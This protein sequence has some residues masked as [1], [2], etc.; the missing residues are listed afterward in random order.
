MLWVK[1]LQPVRWMQPNHWNWQQ[2]KIPIFHSRLLFSL[3]HFL[4]FLPPGEKY[5][6]LSP[7][8]SNGL[9]SLSDELR[10]IY[11]FTI[12]VSF[13]W[14][15]LLNQY[16]EFSNRSLFCCKHINHTNIVLLS[17]FFPLCT[18]FTLFSSSF[19]ASSFLFFFFLFFSLSF[20]LILS[21]SF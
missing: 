21:I 2:G 6:L 5:S 15:T 19:N 10:S 3:S 14:T 20:S 18:F 7:F 12:V 16:Y 13:V 4:L 11:L 1:I 8:T 9:K 17:H